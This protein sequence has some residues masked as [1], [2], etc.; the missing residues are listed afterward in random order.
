M[1]SMDQ[2]AAGRRYSAGSPAPNLR[3]FWKIS[4]WML[5]RI[6][7]WVSRA[8]VAESSHVVIGH[9]GSLDHSTPR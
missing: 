8:M 5:A 4:G 2:P 9:I 7:Q 3:G 1:E 6:F